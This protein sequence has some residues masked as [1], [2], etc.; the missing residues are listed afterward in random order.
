MKQEHMDK[1]KGYYDKAGEFKINDKFSKE[2]E[3]VYTREGDQDHWL[4]LKQRGINGLEVCQTD[5]HGQITAKDTYASVRNVIDCMGVERL[6]EEGKRLMPFSTDEINLIYQ[7]GE[8]SKE[9]TL[10]NLKGIEPV[11]H[12]DMKKIVNSTIHKLSA[13]SKDS[14]S[15]LVSTTKNRKLAERDFSIKERLAKAKA[16]L[17]GTSID[18]RKEKG[19]PKKE[20]ISL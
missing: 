19:Q 10:A 16:Q 1:I 5:G 17:K 2:R 9:N 3:T 8:D 20:D 13:L 6:R 15:E 12:D 11:I 4:I 18:G 14:C 7:F